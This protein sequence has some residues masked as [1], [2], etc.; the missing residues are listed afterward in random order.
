MSKPLKIDT[1][2]MAPD[3]GQTAAQIRVEM[4]PDMG[5]SVETDDAFAEQPIALVAQPP[6][7][8]TTIGL[9]PL[10]LVAAFWVVAL[11]LIAQAVKRILRAAGL[12]DRIG[13]HAWRRWM[14]CLPIAVGMVMGYALGPR[15][16]AAFAVT[17]DPVSSLFL[18]GFT[19]GASAPWV[20]MAFRHIVLPVLPTVTI[21]IIERVSGI[22][23]PEEIRAK[24]TSSGL[25]DSPSEVVE[26]RR[27]E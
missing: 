12:R 25:W 10:W 22:A 23:L 5:V 9:L 18:L 21:G 15:V 24:V 2:W 3:M 17:L 19:S 4:A 16:A 8:T 14:F 1:A 27:D 6:D 7:D 13:A 20:Y 11:I 26:V